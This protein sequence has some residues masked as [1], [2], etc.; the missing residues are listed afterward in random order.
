[1]DKVIFDINSMKYNDISYHEQIITDS[2]TSFLTA[3]RR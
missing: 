3:G 1:M 2:A